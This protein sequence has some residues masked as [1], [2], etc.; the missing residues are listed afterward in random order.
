MV[1]VVGVVVVVV[2]VEVEVVLV[3]VVDEVVVVVASVVVVVVVVGVVLVV[4]VVRGASQSS[5]DTMTERTSGEIEVMSPFA[6]S[7]VLTYLTKSGSSHSTR[8]SGNVPVNPL[9]L[10]GRLGIG[11]QAPIAASYVYRR[12]SLFRTQ[13]LP[14]GAEPGSNS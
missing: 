1:V 9:P 7:T 5:V 12:L 13:K 2:E 4:V 8:S 6:S 11:T 3:E 10:G 14:S